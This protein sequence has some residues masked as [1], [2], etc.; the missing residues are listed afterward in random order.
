MIPKILYHGTC[1]MRWETGIRQQGLRGDMG[2]QFEVDEAHMGYVFMTDARAEAAMFSLMQVTYDEKLYNFRGIR[3]LGGVVI[4]VHTSNI[5]DGVEVDPECEIHRKR[6]K[7]MGIDE[8]MK[9]SGL[10]GKWYR[11]FGTVQRSQ[12]FPYL[13]VYFNKQSPVLLGIIE[14]MMAGATVERKVSL[15]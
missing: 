6:Q 3:E 11:Y 4:G 12:I 14:R 5:R 10:N 13:G 8:D 2:R 9:K 15:T 1:R 7:E